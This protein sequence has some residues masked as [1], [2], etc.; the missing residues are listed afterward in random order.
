MECHYIK[1]VAK[2]YD[3]IVIDRPKELA[4][5]FTNH[6][7]VIVHG[8]KEA[9]KILGD[10]IGLVTILLGNTVMTQTRDIDD[11]IDTVLSDEQIDSCMTVWKAQDD[12]PLRAMIINEEGYL[13]F[14]MNNNTLV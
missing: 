7:D 10:E 11:T 13:V 9:Q 3:T 5:T 1:R 8:V 4:Q 2:E 12:H 6:R 14:F